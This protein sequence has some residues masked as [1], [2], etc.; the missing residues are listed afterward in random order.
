MGPPRKSGRQ[1]LKPVKFNADPANANAGSSS[2]PTSSAN[3]TSAAPAT[4]GKVKNTK[5]TKARAIVTSEASSSSEYSSSDEDSTGNGLQP[6][7][8]GKNRKRSRTSN[9][10]RNHGYRQIN[11]SWDI[12]E[13][14]F[15]EEEDII[16]Y[17][18]LLW[19]GSLINIKISE[20][21]LHNASYFINCT[22]S[23]ADSGIFGTTTAKKQLPWWQKAP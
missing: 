12:R 9:S 1:S 5:K 23:G 20:E 3:S 17:N 16:I 21:R 7:R 18:W 6:Q 4:K 2:I 22:S 14:T 19:A 15:T 13:I 11:T 10:T 8:I